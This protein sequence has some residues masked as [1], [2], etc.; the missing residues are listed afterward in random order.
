MKNLTFAF[1]L[2]C[3]KVFSC[4]AFFINTPDEI[5]FA[6]NFD[7]LSAKGQLVQNNRGKSKVA[8]I[9]NA[10]KS[11]SW[12]S[13]YGSV[14]FNQYGVEFPLGGM[15]EKGLV[16]EMLWLNDTKY[17]A[18]DSRLCVNELQWVQYQLDM[19]YDVGEVI[20][21][22]SQLRI[23]DAHSNVHF[24]VA[25]KKGSYAM[26]EFI[27]GELVVSN[28]TNEY[29]VLANNPYKNELDYLK[30]HQGFG[31]DKQLKQTG[32]SKDRFVATC[33]AFNN[34]PNKGIKDYAFKVLDEVSGSGTVW[35]IVYDMN[36]GTIY[37]KTEE[38]STQ[39]SLNINSL[40]FSCLNDFKTFDLSQKGEVK[41]TKSSLESNAILID[42]AVEEVEFLSEV[43]KDY[44]D[45]VKK[46]PSTVKCK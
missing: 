35:S 33:T 43:P 30:Q 4:T 26:I 21:S 13:K 41:F 23:S 3:C 31:G 46:Y 15:N 32:F 9:S 2:V 38:N 45:R 39:R 17:E 24:M 29:P 8:L 36:S 14:T 12:V 37:F 40:D 10:D 27:N 16:V 25:D 7:W 18:T 28:T 44:I 6:K 1:L 34:I 20:S 5:I 42:S 11:K 19:S 22:L